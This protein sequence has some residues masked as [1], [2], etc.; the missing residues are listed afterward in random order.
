M[1]ITNRMEPQVCAD[2][3]DI[4]AIETTE[5]HTVGPGQKDVVLRQYHCAA[6]HCGQPL[7]WEFHYRERKIFRCGPG[8]CDDEHAL[9]TMLRAEYTDE[10]T[11]G[12]LGGMFASLIPASIAGI[13]FNGGTDIAWPIGGA[14]VA[15]V[16]IAGTVAVTERRIRRQPPDPGPGPN[17]CAANG[18]GQPT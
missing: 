7:G 16:I 15:L 8:L 12:F 17:G 6:E 3:P 1:K 13:T 10:T 9:A 18:A 11:L 14:V 5:R 2:H 4:R